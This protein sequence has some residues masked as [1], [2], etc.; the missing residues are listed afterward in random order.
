MDQVLVGPSQPVIIRQPE[1]LTADLG[2]LVNFSVGESGAKPI[3]TQ[4]RY[5]GFNMSDGP[6]VSG[7]TLSAMMLSEAA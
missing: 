1:N 3:N 5:N 7:S 2:A 6:T 4:W